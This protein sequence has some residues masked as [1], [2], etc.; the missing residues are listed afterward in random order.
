[1]IE[2]NDIVYRQYIDISI[3]VATPKG[4]V[5]PIMRNV[6]SMGYT[7]IEKSMGELGLKVCENLLPV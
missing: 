5:V 7:Q 3:A 1:V 6:E 2:N 4:L